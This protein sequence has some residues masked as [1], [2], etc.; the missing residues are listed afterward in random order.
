M[1]VIV[2]TT[3]N[4]ISYTVVKSLG[5]KGIDVF[6]SNFVPFSMAFASRYSRGYFLYP[7]PFRDQEAFINCIIRNIHRLN[8][9]GSMPVFEETFLIAKYK[10]LLPEHIKIVIPDYDQILTTHNKDKWLPIAKKLSI[11]VPQSFTIAELKDYREKILIS[12]FH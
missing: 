8:S 6:T 5:K 9:N 7:S 2:T 11:P 4:R 10:K 1:S 12:L 3:K